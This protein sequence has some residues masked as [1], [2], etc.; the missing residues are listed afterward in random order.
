MNPQASL[1]FALAATFVAVSAPAQE[2]PAVADNRQDEHVVVELPERYLPEDENATIAILRSGDKLETNRYVSQVVPLKNPVSFEM[3][4]A[5]EAAVE[6]EK[7]VAR[8]VTTKPTDGSAPVYAIHVVT[9]REQMP[10]I[11]ETIRAL[12]LPGFVNS[13]GN[14]REAVRV[15]YRLASEM[16]EILA[17]TRLTGLGDVFADDRTNTVY[18]DD[19]EYVLGELKKYVRFF[20]V[21]S[22]QVKI[23]LRIV[24]V[25]E[26]DGGKL[27]LDWEAWK[28]SFGGQASYN[29]NIFEAGQFSRL[30]GLLTLDAR[31]LADFLNYATQKGHARMLHR[32]NL[33]ASNNEP[34]EL[35]SSRRVPFIDYDASTQMPTLLEEENPEAG[36]A[37]SENDPSPRVVAVVPPIRYR[38]ADL[39]DDVEGIAVSIRPIV[40]TEMVRADVDISLNTLNGFDALDRPIVAEHDV[41][42]SV[43]LSDGE[44]VLLG[45]IERESEARYRRGIPGL[46]D[47][48][49]VGRLFGV[50]GMR[51]SR[52]RIF[53]V[54]TPEFSHVRF[55]AKALTDL[56]TTEPLT[57]GPAP[58]V[59]T[60]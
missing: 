29:F 54:A 27:G 8:A 59:E 34:A 43:T 18:F 37:D 3:L 23:D 57:I 22:P 28:R 32:A 26:E 42:N 51:M 30:D 48:A 7:G 41:R 10:S 33:S 1:A 35:S 46:K 6:P 45:S 19:S 24:E 12:D 60:P 49:Y 2:Q 14:K 31:I 21:P 40:G 25:Q 39:G 4:S 53:I 44:P 17:G 9:T 52:S 50:E 56:E 36:A 13:Q 16:A 38:R 15:K 55:E 5:V 11:V 20:D 47:L 58:E